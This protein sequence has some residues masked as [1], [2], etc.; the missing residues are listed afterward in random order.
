MELLEDF[1]NVKQKL[2]SI[3]NEISA[4]GE[5][6]RVNNQL[7][8]VSTPLGLIM[9]ALLHYTVMPQAAKNRQLA[10]SPNVKGN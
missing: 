4:T 7:H 3:E 6:Q 5:K 9:S 8:E 2:H 10:W 1:S